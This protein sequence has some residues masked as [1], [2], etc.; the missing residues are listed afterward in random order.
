MRLEFLGTASSFGVPQIGCT[1]AVCRSADPRDQR[2]RCGLWITTPSLSLLVDTTPDL[3]TQCLRAG[4]TKVDT[5]LITH[6][7]ADHIFG[8]DDVRIFTARQGGELPVYVPERDVPRFSMIFGYALRPAAP[9]LTRPRLRV[10]PVGEAPLQLADLHVQPLTVWH[11]EGDITNYVFHTG[12]ERVA[13]LTDCKSLAPAS[14]E[15]VRGV[16][17]LIIGAL[18]NE[19]TTHLGHCN[20]SEALA[21]AAELG[22][23]QTYLTH[24]T[25][26]MGLHA[27]TT[28]IL[29]P[30]VT[31]AYDG[32]ALDL[33]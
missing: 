5:V 12:R 3:R 24:L 4:I 10:V 27:A 33:A 2:C 25:H 11:G 26:R 18:W 8:L 19:P 16:D 28:G 21:L 30:G 7:H 20:L 22:A 13:Y 15:L 14:K 9:G 32:L 23:R 6:L 1:C 31:L 17:V 29:P